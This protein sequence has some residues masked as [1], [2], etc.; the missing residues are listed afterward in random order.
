[1]VS[2]DYK[3][4]GVSLV[5]IVLGSRSFDEMLSR[6]TYANKVAD[7]HRRVIDSIRELS[8]RIMTYRSDL[9]DAI[10]AH[11]RHVLE[12]EAASV[13]ANAAE[14]EATTF[15]ASFTDEEMAGVMAYEATQREEAVS[16][17]LAVLASMPEEQLV[18]SFGPEAASV[19]A[20]L[21]AAQET[22]SLP[23]VT[24]ALSVMVPGITEEAYVS[25]GTGPVYVSEGTGSAYV[26]EEVIEEIVSSGGA[27]G[28]SSE[29]L[30][31]AWSLIGAG[32]QWSGYN[33]TG[34]NATS[35][36]TCSGV[37]DY[38][39]G[40]D[41]RSSSPETL[42]EEVGSNIKT[43]VSQFEEGDLVF[44]SYGDRAVG[45]VGIY[46]GDG[47]VL[48]SIPNGGVAVREVDYMD[49]VGGGSL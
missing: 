30:A 33:Y 29:F 19:V 26:P 48:D 28:Y 44:Y 21:A 14:A 2:E 3:Q 35:A 32:Y 15:V 41:S 11:E 46:V 27:G 5:D 37:V 43:D 38:A 25:E 45:H 13:S 23:E 49:V 6:V 40:R 42:Y 17:S 16:A 20:S 31:R 34:D 1:M 47:Q 39:L 24:S 22:A 36:F 9:A 10:D 8:G 7:E 12:R 18:S 4:G